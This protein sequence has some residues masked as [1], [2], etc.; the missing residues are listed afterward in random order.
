MKKRIQLSQIQENLLTLISG[1]GINPEI[2]KNPAIKSIVQELSK[3]IGELGCPNIVDFWLEASGFGFVYEWDNKERAFFEVSTPY[4]NQMHCAFGS[5]KN[6]DFDAIHNKMWEKKEYIQY[7]ITLRDRLTVDK[8]VINFDNQY[9]ENDS[10]DSSM[11]NVYFE[12][13]KNGILLLRKYLQTGNITQIVDIDK[14]DS[15][16]VKQ[17]I[18]SF[19]PS[20]MNSVI[21]Q[22]ELKRKFVDVASLTI[23]DSS[24]NR[25]FKGIVPL[26]NKY[27]L[28]DM[29]VSKRIIDSGADILIEPLS[30]EELITLMA[31]QSLKYQE[32]LKKYCNGRTGF[33]YLSSKDPEYINEQTSYPGF[34]F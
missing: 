26:E 5:I 7:Q 19:L 18:S 10:I 21:Y 24:N 22:E 14:I 15:K 12:F 11:E 9:T 2:I 6:R 20:L 13:D 16:I 33:R 31:D 28:Q 27:S 29:L 3:D 4:K 34:K 17:I 8:K 23:E 25:K 32:G 1:T 30:K